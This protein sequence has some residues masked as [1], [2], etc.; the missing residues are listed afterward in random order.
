MS[1]DLVQADGRWAEKSQKRK[2][3]QRRRAPHISLSVMCGSED[4]A[5]EKA[6]AAVETDPP[7]SPARRRLD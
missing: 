4:Y 2:S 1:L 6:R 3:E 5:T 7:Q